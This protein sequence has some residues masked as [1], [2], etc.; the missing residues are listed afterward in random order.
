MLRNPPAIL[1]IDSVAIHISLAGFGHTRMGRA[2]AL[3]VF[4]VM[5]DETAQLPQGDWADLVSPLTA[6]GG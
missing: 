2:D 4:R 5:F 6:C 3:V 1:R